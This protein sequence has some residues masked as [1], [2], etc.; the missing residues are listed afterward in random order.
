MW[1][2]LAPTH[3]PCVGLSQCRVPL[4]AGVGFGAKDHW[5]DVGA[6]RP[7]APPCVELPQCRVPLGT[8]VGFGAKDHWLDVGAPRPH[9]PRQGA[10]ALHRSWELVCRASPAI[11]NVPKLRKICRLLWRQIFHSFGTVSARGGPHVPRTPLR[12]AAANPLSSHRTTPQGVHKP[13]KRRTPPT[14]LIA[15]RRHKLQTS[16]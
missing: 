5:L 6:P 15:V 2:L 7:H 9:A 11:L 13:C 3:P 16:L 8:G 10:Q 1:G 4:G 14:T 12:W